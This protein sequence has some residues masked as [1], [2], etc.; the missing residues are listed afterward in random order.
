M[1]VPA[2]NGPSL[3]LYNVQNYFTLSWAFLG[4]P[5][6]KILPSNAESVDLI[7]DWGARIPQALWPKIPNIKLLKIIDFKMVHIKNK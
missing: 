4:L 3:I 1:E 6:V 2:P 7:P 5:V